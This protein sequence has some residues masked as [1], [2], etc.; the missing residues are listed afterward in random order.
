[1]RNL[2]LFSFSPGI[3]NWGKKYV[4]YLAYN[5]QMLLKA[6]ERDKW[7][8]VLY[9]ECTLGKQHSEALQIISK[10]F[11]KWTLSFFGSNKFLTQ[12]FFQSSYKYI[13]F[14]T[15]ISNSKYFSSNF[16]VIAYSK[17]NVKPTLSQCNFLWLL[18]LTM[19]IQCFQ[20]LM[21]G[22]LR[23]KNINYTKHKNIHHKIINKM[24]WKNNFIYLRISA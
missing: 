19:I 16:P 18:D 4:K 20:Q 3:Q 6:A 12:Q 10:C 15:S 17:C 7:K 9:T 8:V 11:N 1:M 2:S 23:S 24:I 22:A 14:R 13:W 5:I 21:Y